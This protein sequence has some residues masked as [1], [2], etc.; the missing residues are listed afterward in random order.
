M[1]AERFFGR[2]QD[3]PNNQQYPCSFNVVSA[4]FNNARGKHKA[5][6]RRASPLSQLS[7]VVWRIV[8]GFPPLVANLSHLEVWKAPLTIK[9]RVYSRLFPSCISQTLAVSNRRLL[10]PNYHAPSIF[11]ERAI[12]ACAWSTH[13]RGHTTPER[14]EVG[15]GLN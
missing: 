15:V 2:V 14:P 6:T 10:G 9:S 4:G 8:S 12:C 13:Q 5:R 3:R 1:K 7:F 11:D